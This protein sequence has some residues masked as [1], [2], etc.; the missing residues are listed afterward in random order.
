MAART[1]FGAIFGTKG[2]YGI[3]FPDFPG[4]PSQG[5]TLDEVAAMGREALQG[6]VEVMVDYGD[7]IPEPSVV[8]LESVA[9]VFDDPDDP[10]DEPW[11]AV[12]PVTIDLPASADTTTVAVKAALVHEISVMVQSNLQHLTA[13]QFIENAARRELARL[14]KSA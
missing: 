4:S 1:Y 11:I 12:I 9:Q 14:K 2:S 8:T 13:G 10:S 3:V 6:H 7:L 5:A